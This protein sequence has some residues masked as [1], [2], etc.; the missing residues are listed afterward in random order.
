MASKSAIWEEVFYRTMIIVI[1][2]SCPFL[3]FSCLA[4][5]SVSFY[6]LQYGCVFCTNSWITFVSSLCF[7][8]SPSDP[9]NLYNFI[10]PSSWFLF[11]FFLS[12]NTPATFNLSFGNWFSWKTTAK[13]LFVFMLKT[14]PTPKPQNLRWYNLWDSQKQDGVLVQNLTWSHRIFQQKEARN[15]TQSSIKPSNRK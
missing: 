12:Q 14:H 8:T 11:F 3:N 9:H 7:L 6:F 1:L 4:F 5:L 15:H 10:I 13:F 2:H